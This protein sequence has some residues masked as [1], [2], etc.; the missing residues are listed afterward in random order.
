[1]TNNNNCKHLFYSKYIELLDYNENI[2]LYD[3][4]INENFIV[5]EKYIDYVNFY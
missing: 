2:F 4:N 3:L 5:N 1:M